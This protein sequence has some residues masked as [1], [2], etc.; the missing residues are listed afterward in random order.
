MK[1]AYFDCFSGISGDMILGALIDLGMDINF[2]KKELKK[3][4]IDEYTIQAKKILKKKNKAVKIDVITKSEENK[5]RALSDIIQLIGNS[6]LDEDVK[7]KSRKIFYRLGKAESKIHGVSINKI[8]F[9][10]VG[11]V[12][13]I[14]D[15]VGAVIGIK[16][17]KI[18]KIYSSSLNVGKGF[19]KSEHGLLPIPAPA[20]AEL[21]KGIPVYNNKIEKELVT[22][23]GAAII[24]TLA[25]GFDD[26]PEIKIEN[27]GYGAGTFDLEQPNVLRIFLGKIEDN[28]IDII[29]IIETNI[30]DMSP[31]YYDAIMEKLF[32]NNAL[33]VYLT[34]ILMKKNRPTVKLT[35]LSEVKDTENLSRII[36]EETSTFGVRIYKANRKKIEREFRKIKTK[37]GIVK[38][39]LGKLNGKIIKK[40]PEY[41]DCKRI[42]KREKI[43]IRKVYEEVIKKY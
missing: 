43:P 40:Y 29:N 16:K 9:H 12:D 38:I 42:A 33:D 31:E 3:I 34:N 36:L 23:T 1:V 13:A 41:E 39:K 17:L 21:L 6:R 35:V 11:A 7:E 10:E 22:P 2:L 14:I 15:I 28:K 32:E 30:D 27:I 20:T 5:S 18:E 4:K 26:M 19:I 8:H 25:D 24:T 37:Y